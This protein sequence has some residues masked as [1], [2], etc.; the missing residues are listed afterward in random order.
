MRLPTLS[1]ASIDLS[2]IS[3]DDDVE[4]LRFHLDGQAEVRAVASQ[5]PQ[6]IAAMAATE[7]SLGLDVVFLNEMFDSRLV[8]VDLH[9]QGGDLEE[10][11][12][13]VRIG[14]LHVDLVG[15]A[16]KK[17]SSTRSRGYRLVE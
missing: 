1:E 6:Q 9:R 3:V 16:G 12:K 2:K 8:V 5:V 7:A 15:Q 13:L 10:M 4:I 11:A 17:A 14:V